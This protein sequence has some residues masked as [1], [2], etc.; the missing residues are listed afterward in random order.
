MNPKEQYHAY[1]ERLRAEGRPL[2]RYACPDCD[3]LLETLQP[4]ADDEPYD[5][6]TVCPHC[7]RQH[8]KVVWASGAVEAERC[9]A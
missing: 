6:L 9:K 3:E 8:F 7:D 2:A 1:I 5:T 4:S